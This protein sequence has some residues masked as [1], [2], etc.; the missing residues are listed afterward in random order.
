MLENPH[1]DKKALRHL[2]EKHRST[3]ISPV[4]SVMNGVVQIFALNIV[5]RNS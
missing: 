3:E 2:H 5:G 1:N 4:L